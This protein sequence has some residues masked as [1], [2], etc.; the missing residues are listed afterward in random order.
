VDI[1]GFFAKVSIADLVIV[2]YLF[3]WFVLGYAQGAIR[4]VVGILTVTFSFILA[5]QLDVYLGP[6]L[7]SHWTQFPRGY[8][9][10]VGFGTLFAAGVVAFA[11]IVQGTYSRVAVFAQRPIVDELIGGVLGLVQGGLLLMYV[12]IILDQFFLNGPAAAD[13][14]ELPVLRPLFDAL[15][16]AALGQLLHNQLIPGFITLTGFLLPAS[17][18][19]VYA[20]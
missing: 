10:M 4:R 8:S 12:L 1:A 17:V 9:E 5:A 13:Q 11:L 18:R 20:K 16:G 14:S 3:G 15:N 2:A 6:F 19:A 7:A